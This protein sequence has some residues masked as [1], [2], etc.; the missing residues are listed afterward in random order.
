[1]WHCR[2][3]VALLWREGRRGRSKV[4]V[5]E[6]ESGFAIREARW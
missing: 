4:R 6:R 3:T 5:V 2:W 1:M